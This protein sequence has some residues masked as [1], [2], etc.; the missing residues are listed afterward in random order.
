MY[1]RKHRT[2]PTSYRTHHKQNLVQ[3]PTILHK[4]NAKKK[5]KKKKENVLLQQIIEHNR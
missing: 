3:F 1:E 4:S 2:F 5:K